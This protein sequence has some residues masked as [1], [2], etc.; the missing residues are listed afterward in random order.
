MLVVC[1]IKTTVNKKLPFNR[2]CFLMA[3]YIIILGVLIIAAISW[4]FI[5]Y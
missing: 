4:A 2:V 5:F 3:V 1:A